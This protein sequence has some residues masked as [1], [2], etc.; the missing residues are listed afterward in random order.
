[1]T[2]FEKAFCRMVADVS[3][4]GDMDLALGLVAARQGREDYVSLV[5]EIH[6]RLDRRCLEAIYRYDDGA[7]EHFL[8]A[9][10]RVRYLA[11]WIDGV[12]WN[13]PFAV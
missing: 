8:S 3:R 11:T 6:A 9:K 1:M 5:E 2:S 13:P 7:F 4:G 10:R 12:I